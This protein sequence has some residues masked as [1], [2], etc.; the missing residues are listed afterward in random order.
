MINNNEVSGA[1]ED[2]IYCR[3]VGNTVLVELQG[4]TVMDNGGYGIYW[5]NSDTDPLE[6]PIALNT[7]TGNGDYGMYI[8]SSAPVQLYYNDIHGNYL[9]ILLEAGDGSVL[10]YNN[11]YGNLGAYDLN[12]ENEFDV[13][14]RY[15]Y[16]G[17]DW[18]DVYRI[19]DGYWSSSRGVVDYSD[20]LSDFMENED[21]D[22]DTLTNIWEYENGLNPQIEDS[23]ADGLNDGD[24]KTYWG[25]SWN[26]DIDSDGLINILDPDADGDGSSDG[27]EIAQGT[28]PG[29]AGSSPGVIPVPAANHYLLLIG[30]LMLIGLGKLALMRKNRMEGL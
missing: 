26:A 24:E 6:S 22:A 5:R 14:G 9:G 19:L 16:W 3:S 8:E 30:M 27:D 29:D 20:W 1:S 28:D 25:D 18:V 2:G 13:D 7:V 12:N 23:D 4:N 10:N 11:L 17:Q 15:N 21:S